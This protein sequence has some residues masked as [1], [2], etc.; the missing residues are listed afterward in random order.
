VFPEL[1]TISGDVLID[2]NF[3]LSSLDMPAL[4]DVDGDFIVTD[5]GSLACSI[6][7]DIADAITV[8]GNTTIEG[9]AGCL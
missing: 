3:V 8:G 7:Q 6:P 1:A 2:G 5:N 9:N 4:T